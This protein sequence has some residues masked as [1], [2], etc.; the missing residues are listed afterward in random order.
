MQFLTVISPFVTAY[1]LLPYTLRFCMCHGL[2]HSS[3]FSV[4]TD[5]YRIYSVH[6]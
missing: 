3:L 4:F 6:I 2:Y 5:T 1:V